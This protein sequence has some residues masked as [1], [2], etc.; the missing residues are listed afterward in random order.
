MGGQG[1]N[2]AD[3]EGRTALY[4]AAYG[5]H[6]EIVGYLVRQGAH[7]D[8]TDGMRPIMAAAALLGHLGV[9]ET[10]LQHT[11]GQGLD[12]TD[13]QGRTTLY[14]ASE[15]GHKEIVRALLLA[16]ADPTITNSMG[17]T[18][19]AIAHQMRR[20]GCVKVL[21]VSRQEHVH[22]A[23]SDADRYAYNSI[24]GQACLCCLVE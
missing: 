8:I 5:G 13:N 16:G 22:K 15:N 14:W 24:V 18:P 19:R 4:H 23:Q 10:L 20:Q 6:E 9:V 11:E 7:A 12:Q 17:K 1:L 2:Q 3:Y 21:K